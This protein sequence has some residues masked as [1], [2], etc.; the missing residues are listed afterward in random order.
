MD[1]ARSEGIR[2]DTIPEAGA[3]D[4][5][6]LAALRQL[7][8]Q[9]QPQIVQ[10]HSVKSHFLMRM[11][12]IP[13][14]FRWI[15]FH[16]G[17]TAVNLKVRAY[18]QLDRWSL[19]TPRRVVTVC[20]PFAQELAAMGVEAP[21]IDVVPNSI[22]P[23]AA[24]HKQIEKLRAQLGIRPGEKVALAIGRLSR[25]KG[26]SELIA[27]TRWLAPGA[28]VRFVIVG[29]GPELATLQRAAAPLGDQFIFP[30]HFADVAPFYGLADL[31]VLPSHSE[32]SPNVLL[33]AMSAGLPI[34]ATAVGG[35]PE[36][37]A[38]EKSALLVSPRDAKSLAD[39]MT[40]L[41]RDADLAARLGAGARTAAE[42]HSPEERRRKLAAI[43]AR[44]AAQPS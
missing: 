13:K 20:Q 44:V 27:A 32:G 11:S 1:A 36:S 17:Y 26:H 19:R 18:N 2:V 7:I 15:A 42:S 23:R 22:E 37:V 6:T 21:R 14:T 43:Y 29:E 34:V 24:S 5:R 10:T 9:L 39:S 12:D 38:H 28:P 31:F 3:W 8:A 30:G 35:V 33:E 25:E 16:H 4:M 40:R 41:L